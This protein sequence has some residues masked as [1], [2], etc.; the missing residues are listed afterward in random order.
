MKSQLQFKS[1]LQEINLQLRVI[2]SKLCDIG[3]RLQVKSEFWDV[4][5][6]L[7]IKS[8]LHDI[9]SNYNYEFKS[10][11]YEK[12]KFKLQDINF[13]NLWDKKSRL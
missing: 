4:T 10:C 6:Q 1:E 2:K 13:P 3:L 8:E 5:L 12:K 9:N 7:Q 11:N